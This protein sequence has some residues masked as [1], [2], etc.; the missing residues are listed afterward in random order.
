MCTSAKLGMFSSHLHHPVSVLYP[1]GP[2]RVERTQPKKAWLEGTRA[3]LFLGDQLHLHADVTALGLGDA[4]VSSG[5]PSQSHKQLPQQNE[6][7]GG[8][9]QTRVPAA[10]S[11][12]GHGCRQAKARS[13]PQVWPGALHSQATQSSGTHPKF[14]LP[15]RAGRIKVDSLPR[16]KR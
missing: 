5:H 2:P 16:D 3:G 9:K 15:S 10:G 12:N 14:L 13:H 11:R 4:N 7:A 1:S 8:E 6:G